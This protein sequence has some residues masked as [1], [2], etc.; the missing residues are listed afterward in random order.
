MQYSYQIYIFLLSVHFVRD[1]TTGT[2]YSLY[3]IISLMSKGNRYGLRMPGVKACFFRMSM[4]PTGILNLN[5]ERSMHAWIRNIRYAFFA[6]VFLLFL[7]ASYGCATTELHSDSF[8]KEHEYEQTLHNFNQLQGE[9]LRNGLALSNNRIDLSSYKQLQPTRADLATYFACLLPQK[10][11][12]YTMNVSPEKDPLRVLEFQERRAAL[13]NT[14]QS[15][16]WHMGGSV[17]IGFELIP[18]EQSPLLRTVL[19]P[20][21]F[22]SHY[23]QGPIGDLLGGRKEY[24]RGPDT[25]LIFTFIIEDNETERLL[26]MQKFE[27]H[28]GKDSVTFNALYTRLGAYIPFLLGGALG[29]AVGH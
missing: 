24:I 18:Q 11:K 21:K 26:D 28:N 20:M 19:C 15:E 5:K 17:A 4:Y 23:D 22:E 29:Y 6:P 25:F 9:F 10:A 1:E 2:M 3:S 13:V 7:S 12:I 8:V 16:L 27:S 14:G